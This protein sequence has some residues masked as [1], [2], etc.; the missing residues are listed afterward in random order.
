MAQG[1]AYWISPKNKIYDVPTRHVDFIVQNLQLF[2]L[3]YEE[4]A[5]YFKKHNE[6]FGWEGKGREELFIDLFKKGWIRI[7]EWSDKGW[8]VEIW[9]LTKWEEGA[10]FDWC[11]KFGLNEARFSTKK[12]NIHIIKLQQAK[13]PQHMWMIETNINDIL[14]GKIFENKKNSIKN[15][16]NF[17]EFVNEAKQQDMSVKTKLDYKK[18]KKIL[19]DIEVN[20][21]SGN[22]KISLIDGDMDQ[23]PDYIRD[24]GDGDGHL[25]LDTEGLISAIFNFKGK[26]SPITIFDLFKNKGS[27]F[28][29]D[30]N[31]KQFGS[32]KS[33][34]YD[35]WEDI[36][37][38]IK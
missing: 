23:F 16:K 30:K 5:E 6:K 24:Q 28:N 3:T 17:E 4:Y 34:L 2:G 22:G 20:S 19:T 10:I 33:A 11:A 36:Q 37:K 32:Y 9:E 18:L 27:G 25:Y 8:S 21:Y 14:T 13:K 26:K 35:V 15:M 29:N 7:R 1:K 31:Y 12:V 38:N